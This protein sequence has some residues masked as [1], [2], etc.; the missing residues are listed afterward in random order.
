VIEIAKKNNA[1]A[2]ALSQKIP[3]EFWDEVAKAMK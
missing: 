2:K 3:D 1:L